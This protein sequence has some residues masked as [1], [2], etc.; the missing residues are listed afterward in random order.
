M[1]TTRSTARFVDTHVHLFKETDGD[2]GMTSCGRIERGWI[3]RD[4][5]ED[6]TCGFCIRRLTERVNEIAAN[7]DGI[8]SGPGGA[9]YG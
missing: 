5:G 6:V 4:P 3:W 2:R 7:V 1:P 9:L 8:T